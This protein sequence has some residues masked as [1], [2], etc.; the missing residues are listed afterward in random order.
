M[1]T[2]DTMRLSPSIAKI[3]LTRS[4][5]HAWHAH[6]KGGAYQ[7]EPTDAQRR[8]KLLDR[9]LFETGPELV[10]IE[11]S[12]WRTKAAQAARDAAEAERK[13]PVLAHK[14]DAATAIVDRWREQLGARGLPLRGESQVSLLWDSEG[15]PC[16]GILDHLILGTATA[17]IIDLKTVED[18]S[19]E[20]CR[21][22]VVNLNYDVQQAAYVEGVEANY[23][24]IAGAVDMVFVFAEVEPPYA[25]NVIR[26]AGSMQ[27]VGRA[28]WDRAKLTWADCLEA[29][30][31]PGYPS[32]CS[33]VD[34]TRWQIQDAFPEGVPDELA[35]QL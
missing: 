6:S 26:L 28:K 31:W 25:L 11:A 15:C 30:H 14:F 16:K 4:P 9:L 22:A 33:Y 13:I 17:S 21:R 10:V 5:Y 1:Q 34:A 3:L 35:A 20:A 19:L 8:G 23:P 27:M 12:D 2:P 24:A 7:G 18:A 29:G 32:L